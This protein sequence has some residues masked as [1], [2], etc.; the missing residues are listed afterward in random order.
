GEAPDQMYKTLDVTV[1]LLPSEKP[2]YL[3][4]VGRPEDI[5]EAVCRGIDMFDCVMPTRNGRNAMAFT[6]RGPVRLRNAVHQH[7]QRPLDEEC[8]CVACQRYTRSYLRH[9]FVAKEMLGPILLS[10]HNLT[11]YQT[12]V[13]DLRKAIIAGQGAEFRANQLAR[14]QSPL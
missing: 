14:W 1:P 11:F 10:L 13:R 6:S 3:M 5:L 9:L 4:G 2:R 7:D 12:L 8:A